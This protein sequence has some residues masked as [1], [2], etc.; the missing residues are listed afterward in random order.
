MQV[1]T[2]TYCILVSEPTNTSHGTL[3]P[4][5]STNYFQLSHKMVLP[6][7]ANGVGWPTYKISFSTIL[8]ATRHLQKYHK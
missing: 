6:K 3:S 7:N 2:H 1:H 4:R 5:I 8:A